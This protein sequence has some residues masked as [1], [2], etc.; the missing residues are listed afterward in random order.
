MAITVDNDNLITEA[1]LQAHP[2]MSGVTDAQAGVLIPTAT[3]R[4]KNYL[5]RDR[6]VCTQ[7]DVT[8]YMDGDGCRDLW[9]EDGPITKIVSLTDDSNRDFDTGAITIDN[10]N[11]M[12]YGGYQQAD[13]SMGDGKDFPSCIR[14][15]GNGGAFSCG[16]LN[17]KFVGRVGYNDE[18]NQYP[19]PDDLKEACKQLCAWMF[20]I[21]TPGIKSQRTQTYSY[22][23]E[24]IRDGMPLNVKALLGPYVRREI[25]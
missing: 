6:L 17:I 21:P 20:N 12:I 9:M 16:S 24:E 5:N 3:K 8:I 14:L 11:V 1:Q 22:T 15:L 25:Y 7:E 13:A 10:D 2:G 23:A 19:L 18:D 4:I